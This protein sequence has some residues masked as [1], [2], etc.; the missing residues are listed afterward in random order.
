MISGAHTSEIKIKYY[1]GGSAEG[2]AAA[3]AAALAKPCKASI[4]ALREALGNVSSDS[5]SEDGAVLGT[6]P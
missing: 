3:S 6:M 1:L 4:G 5:S 2:A